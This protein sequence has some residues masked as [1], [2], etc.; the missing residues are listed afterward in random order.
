MSSINQI[1]YGAPTKFDDGANETYF[2]LA[3]IQ[4]KTIWQN[5][6][7]PS[8]SLKQ[9]SF[10]DGAVLSSSNSADNVTDSTS[11]VGNTTSTVLFF[12]ALA[13]GVLIA[14]LF[15]FFTFRYFVRSKYGLHVY[16]I[17]HRGIFVASNGS[18]N[19]TD[20]TN[21]ELQEQINYIRDNNYIRGEILT[22]RIN[23]GRRRRRRG[24][25]YSRMKKL[26]EQEIEILFPKKTY[27]DWLNGGRERDHEN[28]DGVLQ[29]ES[30]LASTANKGE[31]GVG[32]TLEL[33]DAQ[34]ENLDAAITR[35]SVADTDMSPVSKV[36]GIE[37]QNM[38]L[39]E[40]PH[41]SHISSADDET[42]DELHFTSG[43]CAICLEVLEDG[44]N[45]RGLI[46]GHVFHSDCLDPWLTK[47][48]ACCPMCKRDYFFKDEHNNS[49]SQDH[50]GSSSTNNPEDDE[51]ENDD[52]DEIDFDAF[53]NDPALTALLQELI[54]IHER[55]RSILSD[56]SLSSLGLEQKAN[57]IVAKKRSNALKLVWWKTMG[58]SKIDLFNWAV[59]TT[60]REYRQ[61]VASNTAPN[62]ENADA[63]ATTGQTTE[64]LSESNAGPSTGPDA[65]PTS[66]VT[67]ENSTGTTDI[68]THSANSIAPPSPSVDDSHIPTNAPTNE[69]YL[70]PYN[71][72]SRRDSSDITSRDITEQRV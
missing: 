32:D 20:L 12:L 24:G 11:F 13:V 39:E 40:V 29:E 27:H 58:I 18:Y 31:S 61:S 1:E 37:M 22:R 36:E 30:L 26:T 41:A 33:N 55:V 48:R 68:S 9:R 50:E 49:L 54:P 64:P 5:I 70:T 3:I 14:V 23:R 60:H 67:N 43:T 66:S 52:D 56:P 65:V 6:D 45:V 2:L 15:V 21:V 42:K 53:R 59:I 47:R 4:L 57:T 10:T 7:H 51:H 63:T 46:C 34:E 17:P 28:R 72:D 69:I 8:M 19:Q 16:P 25:R 62:V 35:T 71:S 38:K 44:D